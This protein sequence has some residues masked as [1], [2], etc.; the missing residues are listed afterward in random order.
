MK[1][2]GLASALASFGRHLLAIGVGV[3]YLFSEPR[4]TVRYPEYY[5]VPEEGYRGEVRF[6]RDKCIGCGLCARICPASAM[7]MYKL[8]GEK[9]MRPGINYQR[10]IFCGYCVSVCPTGA[11]ELTWVNDVACYTLDEMVLSPDE[12][13]RERVSPAVKEG[14]RPLKTRFDDRKGLKHVPD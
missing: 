7:K 10:C 6:H 12:F 13:E 3:K 2:L 4:M 9:R 1:K 8:P 11:L 5:I 14:A